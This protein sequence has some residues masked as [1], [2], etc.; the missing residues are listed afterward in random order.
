[1]S[2]TLRSL[3]TQNSQPVTVVALAVK[4]LFEATFG[5]MLYSNVRALRDYCTCGSFAAPSPYQRQGN[6]G[7]SGSYT[8]DSRN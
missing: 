3:N 2:I 4:N 8:P 7:T 6:Q 5:I 1:M